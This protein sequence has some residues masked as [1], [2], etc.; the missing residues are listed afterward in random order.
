MFEERQPLEVWN[1]VP[2]YPQYEVSD[3]GRVRRAVASFKAPVGK[4]LKPY[5]HVSGYPYVGLRTCENPRNI[6]VHI[7]VMLAFVGEC[8]KGM[9]IRHLDGNPKNC[10]LSNLKYGTPKEN[11]QDKFNHGTIKTAKITEQEVIAIRQ[12]RQEGYT[13]AELVKEFSLSLN[14]ISNIVKRNTWRHV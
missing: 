14:N 3:H 13:L 8:P 1:T 11:A 12:K 5:Y 6:A 4:I 7:L 10:T 2:D 9:E